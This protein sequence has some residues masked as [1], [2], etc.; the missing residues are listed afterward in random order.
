MKSK[1]K[2][3]SVKVLLFYQDFEGKDDVELPDKFE[4]PLKPKM[5]YIATAE[6]ED[7]TAEAFGVSKSEDTQYLVIEYDPVEDASSVYVRE[8]ECGQDL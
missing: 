8:E 1:V 2:K 3:V 4:I 7:G 6:Y 5:E